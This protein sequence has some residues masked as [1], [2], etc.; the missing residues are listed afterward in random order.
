MVLQK[1]YYIGFVKMKISHYLNQNHMKN[2]PIGPISYLS[3]CR[4]VTVK[5]LFRNKTFIEVFLLLFLMKDIV[6]IPKSKTA[7]AT[8]NETNLPVQVATS[9]RTMKCRPQNDG[10]GLSIRVLL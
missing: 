10:S 9:C 5:S 8:E 7:N 2:N 6:W 3:K 1:T 4:K